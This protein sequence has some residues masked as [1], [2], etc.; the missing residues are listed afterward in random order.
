LSW[1]TRGEEAGVGTKGKN[2]GTG[3]GSLSEL[4]RGGIETSMAE[5]CQNR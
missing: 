5:A 1:Q 4:G 3:S 2:I